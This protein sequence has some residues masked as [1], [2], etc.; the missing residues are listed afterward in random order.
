MMSFELRRKETVPEGIRRVACERL[1]KSLEMLDGNGRKTVSDQVV[2]EARKQF[3]Q[4]RGA[5]RMV[6]KE[7]GERE[8]D[9]ENKTLRN[10]GRPLSEVR[11]AKVMVETLD[12]LG[13]HYKKQLSAEAFKN[14]RAALNTRRREL[15]KKVLEKQHAARSIAASLR[16]SARRVSD[17]R[18]PHSGWKGL[19]SGLRQ[20]YQQGR[21]AMQEANRDGTDEAFHEWR[22]RTKD[23]RYGLELL[24]RAWPEAMQPMADS[25]HHLTDL[26]GK[27]HDL[28]VLQCVVEEELKDVCAHDESELLKALVGQRRADLQKEA[29]ELGR[30]LYT[31]SE[32]EFIERLHGYWQAWR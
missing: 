28:V 29:R 22:K 5:L 4:V 18:L 26:L 2:H 24:A 3:K 13:E 9:R 14:L 12:E 21:A 25:S 17:W 20:M 31:E 30:K 8:F 6:R 27:D 10:A 16:K 11:D 7:L 1:E 23:L 32:D 15:R 19:A